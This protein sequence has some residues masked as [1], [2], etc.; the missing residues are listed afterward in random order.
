MTTR[1]VS[2][3]D[4][5]A[6]REALAEQADELAAREEP[7]TCQ[8]I[9]PDDE[10]ECGD[11]GTIFRVTQWARRPDEVAQPDI[12]V[13]TLHV[14]AAMGGR[15][16]VPPLRLLPRVDHAGDDMTENTN[17]DLTL[18]ASG[19]GRCGCGKTFKGDV[20]EGLTAWQ[21]HVETERLLAEV[22]EFALTERGARSAGEDAMRRLAELG[23]SIRKIVDAIGADEGGTPMASVTLVQRVARG[24]HVQQPR[25]RRKAS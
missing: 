12:D 14:G 11:D 17:H 20:V 18:S 2:L 22:R 19:G 24:D 13:C 9:G 6:E 25:R 4:L 3:A 7:L 5:H 16:S 15:L 1:T 21:G 8:F 10:V 23:V